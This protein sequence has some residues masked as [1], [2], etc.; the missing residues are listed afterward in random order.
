M[1]GTPWYSESHHGC[2]N[3]SHFVVIAL[4]LPVHIILMLFLGTHCVEAIHLNCCKLSLLIYKES[5][6]EE[7]ENTKR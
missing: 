1:P 4:I 7:E 6:Q 3:C 5:Q 2:A